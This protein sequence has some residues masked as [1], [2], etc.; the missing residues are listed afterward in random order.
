MF[1]LVRT[2][3]ASRLGKRGWQLNLDFSLVTDRN[4]DKNY[5]FPSVLFLPQCFI[6]SRNFQYTAVSIFAAAKSDM[7]M[8]LRFISYRGK[9]L[10]VVLSIKKPGYLSISTPTRTSSCRAFPQLHST[11]QCFQQLQ[12]RVGI[13]NHAIPQQQGWVT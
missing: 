5:D 11:P 10:C 3:P 12:V 9:D 2:T 4:S 6:C 1:T 8:Q 13:R 7:D